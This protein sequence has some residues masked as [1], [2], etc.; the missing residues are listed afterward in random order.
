MQTTTKRET[1]V[2]LEL[3]SV[4]SREGFFGTVQEM[5]T[6][7]QTVK[8]YLVERENWRKNCRSSGLE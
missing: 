2:D 8:N 4:R 6:C 1:R 3:E 5:I 7:I